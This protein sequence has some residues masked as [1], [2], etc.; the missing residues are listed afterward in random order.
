MLSINGLQEGKRNDLIIA[1]QSRV[2]DRLYLIITKGLR[3]LYLYGNPTYKA[4]VY[5]M[6]AFIRASNLADQNQ[7]KE[8]NIAMSN[9]R[10]SVE[11]NLSQHKKLQSLNLFK[12]AL[13]SS[14][15]PVALYQEFTVL[16][17]NIYICLYPYS[18]IIATRFNIRPLTIS[19]YL[20]PEATD[21]QALTRQNLLI[22]LY[23]LNNK[24]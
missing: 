14:L 2:E 15:Q 3:K 20:C 4:L 16:M 6:Y 12:Y 9:V 1:R 11:H 7:R 24:A 22:D 23:A 5:V 18:S 17:A 21:R 19:Q 13:K 10:I 8:F